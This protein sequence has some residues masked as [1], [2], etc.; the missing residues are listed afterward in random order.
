M[1]L[2]FIRHNVNAL[3]KMPNIAIFGGT[4]DP[5]HWGHLL[6][7]ETALDQFHLDRIIWV[8]TF[9]PPHKALPLVS[10]E[11]RLAMV[12]LAIAGHPAFHVS[13][14]DSQQQGTSYAIATFKA[15]QTLEPN[16][17]WYWII[18]NDAF[19]SLPHWRASQTLAAQCIW[20]VAPRLMQRAGE[21]E[22]A[23]GEERAAGNDQLL[24]VAI[25]L[26]VFTP[27]QSGSKL[28]SS[29]LM[30]YLPLNWHRLEMPSVAVSSSLI[31]Q[32][33]RDKRSIRYLVPESV[34]CY[35]T[36]KLLYQMS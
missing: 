33:C 3:I 25:P 36:E 26:D 34:R 1:K 22:R 15:L 18:G 11:H 30:P 10:F 9:R 13:A 12:S 5:I 6:I 7:A 24:E 31:R 32:Q 28:N 16:A 8:P 20:L 19:Q 17:C 27:S 2:P 23:A 35:I 14:V 29:R 21:G 4:F